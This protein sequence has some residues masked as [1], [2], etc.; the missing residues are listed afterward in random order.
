M[1]LGAY[2]V[3]KINDEERFDVIR[4]ACPGAGACGGMYTANT[5]SSALEVCFQS[6][7]QLHSSSNVQVLGMSLPYS[8]STPATFPR[9][10]TT[11]NHHMETSLISINRENAGM[12]QCC[13]VSQET[14]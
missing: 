2:V 9:V 14:T 11:S 10:S 7:T 6:G 8:S 4:H 1:V 13:K 5:M 3:G 12:L